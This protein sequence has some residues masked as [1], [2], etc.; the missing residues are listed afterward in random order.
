MSVQHRLTAAL[1]IL[2]AT[3]AAAQ[4]DPASRAWVSRQFDAYESFSAAQPVGAPSPIAA[5][6]GLWDWLR[7]TP[8]AGVTYPLGVQ[9]QWL[10]AHPGWPAHTTIRR[11]AEAQAADQ[12]KSSDTEAR[13][14]FQAVPPQTSAGQARHALRKV[15]DYPPG[16]AERRAVPLQRL[17]AERVEAAS[18]GARLTVRLYYCSITNY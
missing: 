8:P 9:A 2:L 1:A 7:R 6:L 15:E 18:A 5:S 10:S 16:P 13:A 3:P 11:R 17:R 12:T 14:F 4:S